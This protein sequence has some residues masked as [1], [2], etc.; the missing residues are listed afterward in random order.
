MFTYD[1]P[2]VGYKI[3]CGEKS[4]CIATDSGTVTQ[5]M[6]EAL[7]GCETVMIESNHDI[8]ML[9]NGFY[10][11]HLK[12]RIMSP[13]GHMSNSDLQS[14]DLPAGGGLQARSALRT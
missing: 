9:K 7:Y 4:I 10:P 8:G 1:V 13:F 11:A 3:S 5:S 14:L 6:L 12:S 2:C